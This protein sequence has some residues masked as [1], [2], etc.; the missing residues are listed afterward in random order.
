VQQVQLW[1]GPYPPPAAV[2]EYEA[3]LPGTFNR[4][5][6]MAEQAQAAQIAT[7]RQAQNY[8][9]R[10]ARRGQLLG[11]AAT[12]V[13]MGCA[14]WC[15]HAGAPW[16]AGLFL[17]VPVMAVVKSLIESAKKPAASPLPEPPQTPTSPPG[18][19]PPQT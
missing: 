12:L 14:V 13:A 2:R 10:D 9:R 7:I 3:I 18:S 1:Q 19:P 6:S 5:V 16:V 4:M 15:V 17:G 8:T 11:F